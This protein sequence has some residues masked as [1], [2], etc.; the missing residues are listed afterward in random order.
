MSL[1]HWI[2]IAPDCH[3]ALRELV[4]TAFGERVWMCCCCG[5]V[6]VTGPTMACDA[7]QEPESA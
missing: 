7:C 5:V 2:E 6:Q 1:P 4:E 3:P